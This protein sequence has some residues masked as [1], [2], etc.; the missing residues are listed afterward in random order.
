MDNNSTRQEQKESADLLTSLVPLAEQLLTLL[1]T[2]CQSSDAALAKVSTLA[3]TSVSENVPSYSSNAAG[4]LQFLFTLALQ[5]REPSVS[6]A[7]GYCINVL[8]EDNKPVT[9]LLTRPGTPF[10]D[11]LLSWLSASCSS[12]SSSST[13]TVVLVGHVL[14]NLRANVKNNPLYAH[15]LM[16]AVFASISHGINKSNQ[17]GLDVFEA[18]KMEVEAVIVEGQNEPELKEGVDHELKESAAEVRN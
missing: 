14:Y 2:L 1:Y 15:D 11:Q 10:L 16:H 5:T 13:Q 12:S 17:G 8:T 18:V 7:A 4:L 9:R 3:A 6:V